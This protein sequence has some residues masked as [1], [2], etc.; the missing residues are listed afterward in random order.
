MFRGDKLS[1][2][3]IFEGIALAQ[4]AISVLMFRNFIFK[5]GQDRV[6]MPAP[7]FMIMKTVLRVRNI[8]RKPDRIVR[9]LGLKKGQVVLDNGCGIGS[10]SFP[11]SEIVGDKGCVYALDI[12]PLAIKT[13]EK[14]I[15]KK[16]ISNIKTILSG[17]D[18]GLDN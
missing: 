8:F 13:V 6:M 3:L 5:Q 9:G 7:G 11:T 17:R 12:H 1:I 18:T 16:S 4:L 10:F 14:E 2:F 15:K